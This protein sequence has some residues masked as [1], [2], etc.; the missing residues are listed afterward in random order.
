MLSLAK[1]QLCL[2]SQGNA[3][4]QLAGSLSLK[5]FQKTLNIP[6][7]IN[8]VLKPRTY[9][10]RLLLSLHLWAYTAKQSRVKYDMQSP[11]ELKVSLSDKWITET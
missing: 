8:C 5:C 1:G 11:S 9:Y 10:M 6:N 4:S 2:T 3:E 7:G